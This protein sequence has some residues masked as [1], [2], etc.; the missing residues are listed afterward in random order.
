MTVLLKYITHE[1]TLM[2]G[3][4]PNQVPDKTLID[5]EHNLL[6]RYKVVLQAFL[7]EKVDLQVIAL[8]CLQVYCYSLQFPKGMLRRWFI[9]LYDLEVIE[10]EAFLQWKENVT[11][12]YPGKGQAL[13]QVNHWLTWLQEAESED[14]EAED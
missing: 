3:V 9:A 5:K 12:A 14:D 1:S 13:F 10:E 7:H 6:E 8:Y 11:D 2:E 4:D